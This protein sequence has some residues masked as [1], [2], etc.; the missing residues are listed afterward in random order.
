MSLQMSRNG[1]RKWMDE[2]EEDMSN[3]Y[4]NVYVMSLQMSMGMSIC[5]Y[6]MSLGM[7]VSCLYKCLWEW[8]P[9]VGE[10]W[11]DEEEAVFGCLAL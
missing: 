7:S 2:E 5:L 1:A 6:K 4:R 8:R 9:K 3:V 11:M 10:K